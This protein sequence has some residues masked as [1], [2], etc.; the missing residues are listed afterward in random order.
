MEKLVVCD[1]VARRSSACFASG[2]D[3][4]ALYLR[5]NAAHSAGVVASRAT[6]MVATLGARVGNHTS[7]QFCELNFSLGTPR[8]GR[9]TVP[10]RVPSASCRGDPNRTIRTVII[11]FGRED[12]RG[13]NLRRCERI[14]L[15]SAS[16]ARQDT[17]RAGKRSA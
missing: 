3:I 2:A 13:C 1:S 8:G 16:S 7:Y 14:S 9:R 12:W 6:F 5:T 4:S 17:G 15:F 10:M 11:V